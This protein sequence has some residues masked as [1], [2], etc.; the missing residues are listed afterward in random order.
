MALRHL[1]IGFVCLTF[2]GCLEEKDIDCSLVLCAAG[3][4]IN[5]E[6]ISEGQNVISNGTYTLE[7]IEVIGATTEEL[8]VKVFSNTQGTTTG[9]LEISSLNWK[10]GS[11]SYTILLGI[12]FEIDISVTFALTTFPCC[13]DRLE[14][15]ELTSRNAIV[16]Y[17]E[18][19]GFFT[20]ILN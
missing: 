16:A 13:G 17:R 20:V 2:L 9:Y 15:R 7:N 14:I 3:D 8:Q 1:I 12:D 6:L 5:L 11:Y 18:N 10:P 19:S 4:S